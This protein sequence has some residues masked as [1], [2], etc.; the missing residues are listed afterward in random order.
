MDTF[1]KAQRS[2]CMSHIRSRDTGPELAVR[3]ALTL[4]GLRYRLHVR[5]LPGT[6]DIVISKRK[7]VI[8]INGCFWHQHKSCR[9][10]SIP[11]SNV[12]YWRRKLE[13]NIE[14]QKGQIKILRKAGWTTMVIWEC[15]TK[16]QDRLNK[17]LKKR[18]I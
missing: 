13:Q 10:Q 8:F 7:L 16:D 3:K 15:H 12:V 1:S 4:L 9:R 5:K 14:N 11:K 17:E 6:P 2:R 18:I